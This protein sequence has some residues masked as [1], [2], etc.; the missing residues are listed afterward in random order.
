MSAIAITV[1]NLSKVY[2]LGLNGARHETLLGAVTSLLKS[3]FANYRNVRNLS[4][5]EDV[6]AEGRSRVE[7]RGQTP[8][9]PPSAPSDII[10]ALRDVSFEVKAGEVVGII[11]RN[12]AGKSTLLKILSRVTEPTRGRAEI[13]GRVASLLEVG[14]GFH[15]DLT[16]RE[17]V[18]LN[19]T[20]LGMKKAEINRKFD[21]IVDF[22]GIDKFID[23]PVKRYSSGM[24]V[25]L[26]FAVAAH[27]D[28]EVLVVDEVLAVGDAAFQRK[29]LGKMSQVATQGKT[30]LFVSHNLGV[31]ASLCP[32]AILL[33]CGALKAAGDS[34]QIIDLYLKDSVHQAG[35][36]E[37][38]HPAAAPGSGIARLRAVRVLSRG[39]VSGDV[40]IDKPIDLEVE[41]W[42]QSPGARLSVS[43]HLLD[44]MGTTVLS[45]ANFPS[46][47]ISPD[48]WFGRPYPR[49]LYR[50]VCTIP[51]NFLN[52][53]LYRVNVVILN[54]VTRR[55]VF[56]REAVEFH[57]QDTG[58]MR[59]EY[60]GTWSGMVRPKLAWKTE[61]LTSETMRGPNA[62]Q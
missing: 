16:G 24:R 5:F 3:P 60:Y 9:S 33:D 50:S 48:E 58:A 31:L 49:G 1:Q 4:R 61:A 12:G 18:Y 32:R 54:E 15:P 55:E 17:N 30:I 26:A 29:C 35:A 8:L 10:W 37:W 56:L 36:R 21:E 44:R 52:E 20:I 57:V 2:R 14:T 42:N 38:D 59:G 7:G 62:S 28:P 27:L 41:Y 13:H 53:G 40:G 43:L 19:G 51:A 47:T 39:E 11:G 45:T 23:T 34:Q 22:S 6:T 46:A 25:R